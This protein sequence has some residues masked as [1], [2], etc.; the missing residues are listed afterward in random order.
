MGTRA[1]GLAKE[2]MLV[3]ERRFIWSKATGPTSHVVLPL[4]AQQLNVGG[5]FVSSESAQG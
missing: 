4:P 1:G 3:R 2:A 5:N